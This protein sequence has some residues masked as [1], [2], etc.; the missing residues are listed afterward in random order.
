MCKEIVLPANTTCC[1]ALSPAEVTKICLNENTAQY[2]CNEKQPMVSQESLICLTSFWMMAAFS[3]GTTMARK[4]MQLQVEPSGCGN[5]SRACVRSC[6]FRDCCLCYFSLFQEKER[7]SFSCL[8]GYILCNLPICMWLS[9]TIVIIKLQQIVTV[10][11]F[12][13]WG[14]KRQYTC[15]HG[16][17]EIRC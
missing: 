13:H 10:Y 16:L 4:R 1:Q 9:G 11:V 12:K 6:Y 5:G 2:V 15:Y 17:K 14:Y 3:K 7:L 8:H